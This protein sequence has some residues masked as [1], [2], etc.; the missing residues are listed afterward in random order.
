MNGDATAQYLV[1]PVL[2]CPSRST[3][4]HLILRVLSH[5]FDT[6]KHLETY[7][8]NIIVGHVNRN[9]GK[10]HPQAIKS[11]SEERWFFTAISA[12]DSVNGVV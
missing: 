10:K 12:G 4:K 8:I 6:R 11:T 7:L 5:H 9:T 1:C 3:E 2:T